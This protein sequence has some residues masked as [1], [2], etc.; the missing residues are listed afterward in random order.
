MTDTTM[1]KYM[2]NVYVYTYVSN[3]NSDR[4]KHLGE[5]LRM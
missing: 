2:F 3:E 1:E 4:T 5:E